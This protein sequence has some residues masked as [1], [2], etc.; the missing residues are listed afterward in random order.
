MSTFL[1]VLKEVS[2]LSLM[3]SEFHR[4]GPDRENKKFPRR[5]ERWALE[6]GLKS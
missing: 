2:F 5:D 1:K 6:E 3:W 4:E